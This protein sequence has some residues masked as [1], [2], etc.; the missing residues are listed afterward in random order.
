MEKLGPTGEHSEPKL[1]EDDEGDL[2]MNVGALPGKVVIRFGKKVAW[3][4][5]TPEGARN[6]AQGLMNMANAVEELVRQAA[7][8][9]TDI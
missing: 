7:E 9:D 6:M 8:T 2:V 5:M 4:G 1:N 3:V